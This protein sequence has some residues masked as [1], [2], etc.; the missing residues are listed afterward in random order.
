MA[1]LMGCDRSPR[2]IKDWNDAL[3][4]KYLSFKHVDDE[5]L[6]KGSFMLNGI[7]CSLTPRGREKKKRAGE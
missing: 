4:L 7:P 5:H 3:Y 2:N 6:L 1:L